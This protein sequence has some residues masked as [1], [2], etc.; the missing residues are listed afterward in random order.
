MCGS[1]PASNQGSPISSPLRGG[2]PVRKEYLL[3]GT[4]LLQELL[5]MRSGTLFE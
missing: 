2:V 4:L 3:P 5:E 1:R